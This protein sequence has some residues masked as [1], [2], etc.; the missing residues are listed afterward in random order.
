MTL[1]Q[2]HQLVL[3]LP[4]RPAL[5]REAFYV[6]PSN[7]LALAQIDAWP[8][9][10]EGRMAVTGPAGAGKTH[11]T[12]VWAAQAEARILQARDL[13]ALDPIDIPADCALAVEDAD[14]ICRD[15]QADRAEEALF[16]LCNRLASGGGTLLVSGREA[17]AHWN[18]ALPD[19]A[20]R[21]RVAGVARLDVPDD[22]L[23][24]ALLLKLFADRQV[25]VSPDLVPYLLPRIDRSFAG[26]EAMVRALDRAALSRKRQITPRLAA[27]VLRQSGT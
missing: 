26:A 27:E 13:A 19:L 9:W 4:A 6:S 7:V 25:E 21:L 11:L 24:S 14:Q 17:P 2:P 5:G 16:H 20:S 18:L 3:D 23:L 22:D 1:R 15:A 12:H 10:P 8:G